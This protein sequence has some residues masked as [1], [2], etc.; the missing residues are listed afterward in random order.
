MNNRDFN[1]NSDIINQLQQLTGANKQPRLG[2][3]TASRRTLGNPPQQ[4]INTHGSRASDPFISV[5]QNTDQQMTTGMT[6]Y[7]QKNATQ[8]FLNAPTSLANLAQLSGIS[9]VPVNSSNNINSNHNGDSNNQGPPN[10]TNRGGNIRGQQAKMNANS[11]SQHKPRGNI[12]GSNSRKTFV[13]N[14]GESAGFSHDLIS[15]PSIQL[16]SQQIPIELKDTNTGGDKNNRGKTN[17]S[18]D[19]SNMRVEKISNLTRG[20]SMSQS[21]LGTEAAFDIRNI[22]FSTPSAILPE[23][24]ASTLR[25]NQCVDDSRVQQRMDLGS[26]LSLEDLCQVEPEQEPNDISLMRLMAVLNNPALTLTPVDAH[27]SAT[28][29]RSVGDRSSSAGTRNQAEARFPTSSSR[30]NRSQMSQPCDAPMFDDIDCSNTFTNQVTGR[31]PKSAV[32][33]L[34]TGSAVSIIDAAN[35]KFDMSDTKT[36]PESTQIVDNDQAALNWLSNVTLSAPTS[37]ADPVT[38]SWLPSKGAQNE[39]IYSDYDQSGEHAAKTSQATS[40]QVLQQLENQNDPVD[41][42]TNDAPEVGKTPIFESECIPTVSRVNIQQ[43]DKGARTQEV[44]YTVSVDENVS[45]KSNREPIQT[46]KDRLFIPRQNST[47]RTYTIPSIR[48]EATQQKEILVSERHL[49]LEKM[50]EIAETVGQRKH[51]HSEPDDIFVNRSKRIMSRIDTVLEKKKRRRFERICHRSSPESTGSDDQSDV[52]EDDSVYQD[53]T[54]LV[55]S[56]VVPIQLP[57]EEALTDEKREF[58]SKVGLISR[59]DRT[60]LAVQE[61]E[62]RLQNISAL[63]LQDE[64]VPED[65]KRFVDTIFQTGG[66]DVQMR[67]ET[68]IKRN[69][70]PFIEGLNRNT[71]RIKMSYMSALGLEK[72]SKRTTLYKVTKPQEK[73]NNQSS[74]QKQQHHDLIPKQQA[75]I[76]VKD[77]AKPLHGPTQHI[78]KPDAQSNNQA[79]IEADL[80]SRVVK[81]S[82]SS[83]REAIQVPK[84]EYMRSLGLMA[85]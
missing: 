24:I 48:I 35:R 83:C 14:I 81:L 18:T 53:S 60:K 77:L 52:S 45:C 19:N 37:S 84:D 15:I 82:N 41:Y 34:A 68:S 9:L 16:L 47:R 78:L 27:S 23:L 71:S 80:F 75:K 50:V 2:N 56:V 65:L 42:L 66:I 74:T 85:S 32:N 10:K 54:D 29:A 5:R 67:T 28:K 21:M 22:D 49:M 76:A 59:S 33:L 58:L 44:V 63:A 3:N 26:N 55:D 62:K 46:S 73:I 61:C 17:K 1:I 13:S 6:P 36:A 43:L 12:H 38:L 39:K 69:E 64:V 8:A 30:N 51:V 57:L 40:V 31:L 4:Q 72:R 25:P 79:R 11:D 7:S 70:L 20:A